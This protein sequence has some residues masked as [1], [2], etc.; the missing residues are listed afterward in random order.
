MKPYQLTPEASKGNAFCWMAWKSQIDQDEPRVAAQDRIKQQRRAGL[1]AN[2][3][4]P[5]LTIMPRKS[6][7]SIDPAPQATADKINRT[8]R[9]GI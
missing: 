9:G 2:K 8:K 7:I 5:A 1:R 6:G 3:H 4:G